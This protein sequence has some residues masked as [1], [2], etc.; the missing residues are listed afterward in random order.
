MRFGELT[1]ILETR[2]VGIQLIT[3]NIRNGNSRF[4]DKQQPCTFRTVYCCDRPNRSRH[5]VVHA[6]S[7]HRAP[8]SST[9]ECEANDVS[10]DGIR[11][12]GVP[13]VEEH[14]ATVRIPFSPHV[15]DGQ[16]L[17]DRK[18]RAQGR[19]AGVTWMC[20]DRNGVAVTEAPHYVRMDVVRL[21][22]VL[23]V[24]SRCCPRA[25]PIIYGSHTTRLP[26]S[27]N[28]PPCAA[29]GGR[30]PSARRRHGIVRLCLAQSSQSP[31]RQ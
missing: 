9:D 11:R 18:G 6:N 8:P 2:R 26:R 12:A 4:G 23:N 21:Q 22:L 29:G 20:S 25:R 1:K 7:D 24:R 5:I 14:P 16:K 19:S 30:S 15:L 17:L 28:D 27:S 10:E 3:L 31:E 13:N